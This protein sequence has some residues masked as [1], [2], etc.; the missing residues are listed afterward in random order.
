M[1]PRIVNV[2]WIFFYPTVL[3]K[4]LSFFLFGQA[5]ALFGQTDTTTYKFEDGTQI[6]V[7]YYS[8]DP[9]LIRKHA[10]NVELTTMGN[11][12]FYLLGYTYIQPR[13]FY[14][15][16]RLGF[17]NI[18][19]DMSYW[20]FNGTKDKKLKQS[21][22]VESLGADHYKAY[23]VKFTVP[24]RRSFGPRVGMNLSHRGLVPDMTNAVLGPS[25][26][27]GMSYFTNYQAKVSSSRKQ[28]V[29]YFS[30]GTRSGAHMKRINADVSYYFNHGVQKVTDYETE[31]LK[32]FTTRF[33]LEGRFTGWE[34]RDEPTWFFSYVLG[35]SISALNYNNVTPLVGAGFTVVFK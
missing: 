4:I 30:E 3:K 16:T 22:K 25:V 35:A 23:M 28:G 14:I 31:V 12:S 19:A 11:G 9:D 6:R 29:R 13:K 8:R 24:K 21:V 33:Y 32:K 20:I 7:Q 18:H 2:S 26:F 15:Q 17:S 27:A 1:D 10:L 34:V 5:I